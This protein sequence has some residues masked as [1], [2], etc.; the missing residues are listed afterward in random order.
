MPGGSYRC[1]TPF[2]VCGPDV[3]D[4]VPYGFCH[5]GCGQKTNPSRQTDTKR[6]FVRGEP[7]RFCRHHQRPKPKAKF[8][9]EACGYETPCWIW[10]AALNSGG[11]GTTTDG[12]GRGV[13]AHRLVYEHYRGTI[14]EGLF[15]DHLC[16]NP[17]CVNPDH[18]EPVT[19]SENVRRGLA[20]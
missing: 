15:L 7:H 8:K 4:V 19:N 20:A 11:Y 16:R 10:Q 6:G 1:P 9:I 3:L 17:A 14:P 12:S 13:M 5:C 18:L 2:P